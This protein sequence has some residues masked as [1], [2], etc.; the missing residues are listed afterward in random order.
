MRICL[1]GNMNNNNYILAKMLRKKGVEADLIL[2]NN[3]YRYFLPEHY[4][5]ELK[6]G[7]PEWIRKVRWGSGASFF[8]TSKDKILKDLGEYD[9][10]IAC[11]LF[12]PAFLYK[13]GLINRTIIRP[14]GGDVRILPFWGKLIENYK[15]Y[16]KP[17]MFFPAYY[18]SNVQKIAIKN[19]LAIFAL[20]Q[21]LMYDSLA[22]LNVLNKV[23][24][25]GVV[26]DLSL[27]HI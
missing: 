17:L 22:K 21:G 2:L 15:F 1:V 11:N 10:Y 3:E 24:E 4:D 7:Y 14:H 8:Y 12:A 18:L 16:T 26:V 23:I 25:V 13:A 5:E 27:I 9:I 20:P 6:K 19:C